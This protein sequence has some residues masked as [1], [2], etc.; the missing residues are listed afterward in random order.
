MM[1]PADLGFERFS[2]LRRLE[3]LLTAFPPSR[4]GA[5]RVLDVDIE[6]L[7][8]AIH[9]HRRES[10][11]LQDVSRRGERE[12]GHQ[13]LAFDVHSPPRQHHAGGVGRHADDL[14]ITADVRLDR[15]LQP[16]DPDTIRELADGGVG[17]CYT[18]GPM[19]NPDDLDAGPFPDEDAQYRDFYIELMS[20]WFEELQRQASADPSAYAI[21][22]VEEAQV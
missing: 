18:M 11:P 19:F 4:F 14:G 16:S 3:C 5:A 9:Q 17:V 7:A 20:P 12:R 13:H 15:C 8:I 2:L 6:R 21:H 22:N 10:V 1:D